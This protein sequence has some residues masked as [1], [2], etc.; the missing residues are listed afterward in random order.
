MYFKLIYKK[1]I[2]KS[3]NK[4][5]MTVNKANPKGITPPASGI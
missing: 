1:K 3:L 4:F 5:D 2:N